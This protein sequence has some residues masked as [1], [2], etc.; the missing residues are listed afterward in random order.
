MEFQQELIT[1]PHP[2]QD[3]Q[4]VGLVDKDEAEHNNDYYIHA[5]APMTLRNTCIR[6]VP[7]SDKQRFF[8]CWLFGD[9]FS[10]K[11]FNYDLKIILY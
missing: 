5:P 10:N 1:C 7:F 11:L 3:R 6:K 9:F 8:V 2:F 4:C